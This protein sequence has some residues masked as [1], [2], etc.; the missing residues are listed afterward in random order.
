M[1]QI[2]YLLIALFLFL[3]SAAGQE[4]PGEEPAA[5]QIASEGSISIHPQSGTVAVGDGLATLELPDEL[6]FY[7]PEDT[8]IILTKIWSN[9]PGSEALGM[10]FP[11]ALHPEDD[12]AWGVI[13]SYEEDGYV[14]DDDAENIDYEEL[15]EEMQQSTTEGNDERTELGYDPVTLVGWAARPHYDKAAHKLYWAKNLKFG[16]DAGENTLN[17]NIR[18]LGRRGVLVMNAVASMSQLNHIEN[19]MNSVMAVVTFN[20]GN[21]YEDFNP[22]LDEVAAYGIGALIA[23]KVAAKVGLFKGLIALLIAGKKFV[24]VGAVALLALLRKI[25]TGKA[26]EREE[27]VS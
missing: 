16:A 24:V 2:C 10:I 14:D 7:G 4:Q 27:P 20:D 3:T 22:E 26:A 8:E 18:V 5:G 23:G 15:L 1:K 17:Y 19:E 21:R 9:P 25:F 13:I 12:E 6:E 11:S